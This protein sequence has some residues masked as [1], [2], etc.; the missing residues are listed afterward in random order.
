MKGSIT[1]DSSVA[2]QALVYMNGSSAL[3][4]ARL[5]KKLHSHD[6]QTHRLVYALFIAEL[7]AR[8]F[9]AALAHATMLAHLLQKSD[10]QVTVDQGFLRRA[11]FNEMQRTSITLSRSV[12][13]LE[14]W[15]PKQF[16]ESWKQVSDAVPVPY[17]EVSRRL[18]PSVDDPKLRSILIDLREQYIAFKLLV[19]GS[20]CAKRISFTSVSIHCVVCY[21]RL[22]NHYV[23]VTT[24]LNSTDTSTKSSPF[25]S[26]YAYIQAYTCLAAVYWAR[27]VS[28]H[29]TPIGI[30]SSGATSMIFEAGPNMLKHLRE[31][32]LHSEADMEPLQPALV[33][34]RLRLWALYLGAT[35]ERAQAGSDMGT[36]DWWYNNRF[37]VQAK[38]MDLRLWQDVRKVL[39]DFLYTDLI[40]PDGSLWFETMVGLGQQ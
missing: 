19:S 14:T 27:T 39:E 3:L 37:F 25:S 12:F 33:Y 18:D 30:S 32:L 36:E 17:R 13:D 20:A 29:D 26:G 4:R 31:A 6:F 16:H 2:E 1:G 15:V 5:A 35:A 7:V 8:N 9:P 34:P 22:I 10:G 38:S 11:L 28:M 40:Q 23:N 21:L 24:Q